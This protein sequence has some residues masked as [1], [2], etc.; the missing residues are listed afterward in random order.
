MNNYNNYDLKK[1][2]EVAAELGL[3]FDNC[4]K[5]TSRN[6]LEIQIMQNKLF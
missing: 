3:S 4:D 5:V 6:R 2:Y 1:I